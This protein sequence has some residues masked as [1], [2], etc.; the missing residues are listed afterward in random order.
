MNGK[1]NSDFLLLFLILEKCELVL[2]KI[3]DPSNQ[4]KV[5]AI[6]NK[7]RTFVEHINQLKDE[8]YKN[9]DL[10]SISEKYWR[11]VSSVKP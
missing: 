5:L 9:K 3:V 1:F 11:N 4:E 2:S 7:I 8:L 6:R 10:S